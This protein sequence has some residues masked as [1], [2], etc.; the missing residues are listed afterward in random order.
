M[1]GHV[2]DA[3][4]TLLDR[5]SDL[6][7]RLL[8]R[9]LRVELGTT[10]LHTISNEFPYPR[11]DGT[12]HLRP[13]L[14]LAPDAGSGDGPGSGPGSKEE[15][16]LLVEVQMRAVAD[17]PWT[18]L[19]YWG[20]AHH[21]HH[22]HAR[23]VLLALDP[24]THSWM[25]AESGTRL[26]PVEPL[27]PDLARLP[28]IDEVEA[29]DADPDWAMLCLLGRARRVDTRASARALLQ[30]L[31]TIDATWAHEYLRLVVA[32]L[33]P[34]TIEDIAS[35]MNLDQEVTE[36]ERGG[37][38]YKRSIEAGLEQGREQG[39]EQG[40]QQALARALLRVLAA[41]RLEPSPAQSHR[42]RSCE[43]P[44]QL[45]TWIVR[46]SSAKQVAELFS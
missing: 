19:A 46:A 33:P 1:P 36:F 37:W 41:K 39:L 16:L 40:R 8:H 28:A 44:D 7:A 6:L 13:D 23:L 26:R 21:L 2:H 4:V 11:A 34:K 25:H 18:L 5:R 38:L 27:V 31:L 45:E 35:E 32:A 22:R 42:I 9:C 15:S 10:Q 3:L 24:H 30:Y 43:D 14:V 29:V 17:K 12:E 20:L